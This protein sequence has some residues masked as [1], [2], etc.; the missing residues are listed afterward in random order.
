MRAFYPGVVYLGTFIAIGW[1]A[2]RLLDRWIAR[3]GATL[4]EVNEQAGANAGKGRRFL[5]GFWRRED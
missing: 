5:L 2:K 3:H 1:M 4:E